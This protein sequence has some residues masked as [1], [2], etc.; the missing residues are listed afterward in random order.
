MTRGSRQSR[1]A[2][3]RPEDG[4]WSRPL[5]ATTTGR[6]PAPLV[7]RAGRSRRARATSRSAAPESRDAS[8]RPIG[9]PVGILSPRHRPGEGNVDDDESDDDDDDSPPLLHSRSLSA[10]AAGLAARARVPR[11]SSEPCLRT[12]ALS[13]CR[14]SGGSGRRGRGARPRPI[15]TPSRGTRHPPVLSPPP[16]F[17]PFSLLTFRVVARRRGVCHI[18]RARVSEVLRG[19]GPLRAG[20]QT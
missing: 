8:D 10:C 16:P 18:C 7:R 15:A 4:T 3:G 11:A 1:A 14:A 9:A 5:T 17:S 19:P 2:L 20:I 6:G 12:V 13:A